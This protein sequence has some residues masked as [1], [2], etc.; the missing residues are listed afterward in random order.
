MGKQ[1]DYYK[2]FLQATV[3]SWGYVPPRNV[4]RKKLE[5]FVLDTLMELKSRRGDYESDPEIP[6]NYLAIIT[7]ALLS[8]N[9]ALN[10][11][12]NVLKATSPSN[13]NAQGVYVGP[14]GAMGTIE[15]VASSGDSWLSNSAEWWS[16]FV[17]GNYADAWINWNQGAEDLFSGNLGF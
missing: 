13:P 2:L 12:S 8:R 14:E 5:S 17:A 4:S 3:L 1:P 6:D 7:P 11:I 16:D 10:D 15:E 9:V